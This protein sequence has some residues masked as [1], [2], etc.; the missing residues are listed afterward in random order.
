MEPLPAAAAMRH[1]APG[2]GVQRAQLVQVSQRCAALGSEWTDSRSLT[3]API[4][5]LALR[6]SEHLPGP[7]TRLDSDSAD[8]FTPNQRDKFLAVLHNFCK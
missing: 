5:P 1:N 8:C 7:S 3:H 6:D 4:A 2:H